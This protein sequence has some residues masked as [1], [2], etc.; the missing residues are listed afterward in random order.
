MV[1]TGLYCATGFVSSIPLVGRLT[2]FRRV[3]EA[4]GCR[5][6][7]G[8][9]ADGLV[10]GVVDTFRA[11]TFFFLLLYVIHGFASA[12]DLT[13]F[14]AWFI[15]YRYRTELTDKHSTVVDAIDGRLTEYWT[16][17]RYC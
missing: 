12:I 6:R 4:Y 3:T 1:S 7:K 17:Y 8:L 5:L 9:F 14:G 10:L 15:E 16:W 13:G 2:G 11:C